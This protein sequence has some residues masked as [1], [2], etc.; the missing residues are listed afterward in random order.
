MINVG[1]I[2]IKSNQLTTL[3][4]T[5][6]SFSPTFHSHRMN[7]RFVVEAATTAVAARDQVFLLLLLLLLFL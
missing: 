7:P 4:K 6:Y 2:N 1:I 5:A 3:L